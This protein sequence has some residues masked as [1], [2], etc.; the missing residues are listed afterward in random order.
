MSNEPSQPIDNFEQQLSPSM[1]AAV[2]REMALRIYER[3]LFEKNRDAAD[4]GSFS[5]GPPR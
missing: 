5:F 2:D 1:Q 4:D 3:K